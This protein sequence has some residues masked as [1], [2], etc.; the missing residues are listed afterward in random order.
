MECKGRR[1]MKRCVSPREAG[2]AHLH[3]H[4]HLHLLFFPLGWYIPNQFAEVEPLP[5][6]LQTCGIP[7]GGGKSEQLRVKTSH[8]NDQTKKTPPKTTRWS[9]MRG[10]KTHEGSCR[11]GGNESQGSRWMVRRA[12]SGISYR[13]T[14]NHSPHFFP[15]LRA[16]RGETTKLQMWCFFLT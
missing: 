7:R 4:L 15:V 12:L 1:T 11:G 2:G 5:T 8:K 9:Q 6:L 14:V 13:H 3:L 10:R 16:V